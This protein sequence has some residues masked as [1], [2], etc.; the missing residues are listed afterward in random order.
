MK[1]R[2]QSPV[3]QAMFSQAFWRFSMFKERVSGAYKIVLR[4]LVTYS[5]YY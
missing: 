1:F 3:G 2:W 5:R 4:R